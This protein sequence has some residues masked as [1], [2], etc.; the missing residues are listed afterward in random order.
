MVANVPFFDGS[1]GGMA[2]LPRSVEIHGL[3]G[4]YFPA[5]RGLVVDRGGSIVLAFLSETALD[6]KSLSMEVI[7]PP[8]GLRDF[9]DRTTEVLTSSEELRTNRPANL[10]SRRPLPESWERAFGWIPWSAN[11]VHCSRIGDL[12][13]VYF[14]LVSAVPSP[15]SSGDSL[16]LNGAPQVSA[17]LDIWALEE[18]RDAAMAN[19]GIK[20]CAFDPRHT[21][22]ALQAQHVRQ[23][24]QAPP[25]S[26]AH[27]SEQIESTS[28]NS[29]SAGLGPQ[30]LRLVNADVWLEITSHAIVFAVEAQVASTLPELSPSTEADFRRLALRDGPLKLGELI[31]RGR[32]S[33]GQR[34][35]AAE[36]LGQ[37]SK[38]ATA[39]EYLAPL[40]T[41]RELVVR[42][43]AVHGLSEHSGSPIVRR[44][45]N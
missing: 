32:L 22:N 3:P 16:P 29:Q 41:A 27:D 17:S 38:T 24:V 20:E 4:A 19:S 34:S 13:M 25:P 18:M 45:P 43:G 12:A 9:V 11:V 6:G 10:A 26:D 31:R 2:A 42:E 44:L 36:A 14:F 40:L 5:T 39:V 23:T 1:V 21:M 37:L 33:P 8:S 35:F 30:T 15:L 28:W 7:V